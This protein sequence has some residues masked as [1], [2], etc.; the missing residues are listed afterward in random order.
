MLK[1]T[2]VVDGSCALAFCARICQVGNA[3]PFLMAGAW[4]RS[5]REAINQGLKGQI[6]PNNLQA[7]GK[8]S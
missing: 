8:S 6:Q 3:V 4:G 1:H 7:S 5:I 2:Q